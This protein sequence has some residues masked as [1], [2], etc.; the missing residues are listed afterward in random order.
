[1]SALH[2][3]PAAS[4]SG[5]LVL[6]A[7]PA[8]PFLE[9]E[10]EKQLEAVRT[11]DPKTLPLCQF[12]NDYASNEGFFTEEGAFD[13]YYYLRVPLE[14]RARLEKIF[15]LFEERH[16]FA[17]VV[18]CLPI[19]FC[20]LPDGFKKARIAAKETLSS[21]SKT[22]RYHCYRALLEVAV[23]TGHHRGG[24][25]LFKSIP[26]EILA[27]NPAPENPTIWPAIFH[28]CASTDHYGEIDELYAKMSD[29]DL[30]PEDPR[31]E[32]VIRSFPKH[33]FNLALSSAYIETI[34]SQPRGK[35]K[36]L[37]C[38]RQYERHRLSYPAVSTA[39]IR[40][41]GYKIRPAIETATIVYKKTLKKPSPTTHEGLYEFYSAYM[42][43]SAKSGL[44]AQSL[45]TYAEAHVA[46]RY[47]PAL[48]LLNFSL[49][50]AALTVG[51]T[52][53]AEEIF[54]MLGDKEK[55]ELAL[56]SIHQNE[57]LVLTFLLEKKVVDLSF[58]ENEALLVRPLKLAGASAVKTA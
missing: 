38:F 33:S 43:L 54:K 51:Q 49:M 4:S 58:L 7:P 44:F 30:L 8:T 10:F 36:A 19:A 57:P 40:A 3:A 42:L 48:Q 29:Y 11:Q 45:A 9:L 6:S 37:A 25:A 56:W 46:L 35:E 17:Y 39:L 20:G 5:F 16:L 53:Q 55:R 12:F 34:A 50:A 15:Q 32:G 28:L 21:P 52:R 27:H 41:C 18:E 31:C 23:R 1:M 47:W 13:D 24:Y 26:V 22:V 14:D 2:L